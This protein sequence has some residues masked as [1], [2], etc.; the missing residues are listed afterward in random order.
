MNY[1]KKY[2]IVSKEA[3]PEEIIA[4]LREVYKDRDFEGFG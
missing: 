3:T 4:E 2:N 1:L